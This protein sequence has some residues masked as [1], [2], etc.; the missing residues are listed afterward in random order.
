M[1][2]I[3]K[4]LFELEYFF[5]IRWSCVVA[6][7]LLVTVTSTREILVVGLT[8]TLPLIPSIIQAIHVGFA[9]LVL[10]TKL[11]TSF[12]THISQLSIPTLKW[13]LTHT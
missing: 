11:S 5:N 8:S 10:L 12:S 1:I 6:G 2:T 4:T 13:S 3:A 7:P 9:F